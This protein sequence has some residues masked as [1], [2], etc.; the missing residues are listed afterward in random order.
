[1]KNKEK[2]VDKSKL[3]RYNKA[4]IRDKKT[5][6]LKKKEKKQ[7]LKNQKYRRRRYSPPETVI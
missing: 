7:T 3:I 1:M 5:K 4:K 6:L 2:S